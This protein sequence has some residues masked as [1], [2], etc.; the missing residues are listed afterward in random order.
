MGEQANTPLDN[1]HG[2]TWRLAVLPFDDG[3]TGL[4]LVISHVL[5]DGVGFTTALADAASGRDEAVTWAPARSRRRWSALRRDARQAALDMPSVAQAIGAAARMVWRARRA[6]AAAPESAPSSAPNEQLD[7]PAATVFVDTREWD[8]C[9][10]SLGGTSNSLLAG[11]A[12]KFAQRVGR[13]TADEGLAQLSMPINQRT[14]G[15]TRAN[16]VG[17]IDLTVDPDEGDRR[18]PRDPR[19]GQARPRPSK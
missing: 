11:F 17:N 16:A 14:D 13:V 18:P 3:G 4:S 5:T 10:Q 9:A 7:L 15:D 2:P 8:A 19:R 1:E 12:A 6:S